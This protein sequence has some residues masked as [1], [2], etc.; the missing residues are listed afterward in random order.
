[1]KF[2]SRYSRSQ[3]PA[4]EREKICFRSAKI[5]RSGFLHPAEFFWNMCKKTVA[6][7][8]CTSDL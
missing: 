5:E 3:A 1:M 7:Y 6:L 2:Y 8:L 4:W